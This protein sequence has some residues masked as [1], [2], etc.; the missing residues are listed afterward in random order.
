MLSFHKTLFFAFLLFV[1]WLPIPLG[2]NRPWAW[3]LN[4]IYV[5]FL[6]LGCL[7]LL[8]A[9]QC[10]LAIQRAKVILIPVALFTLWSW[11]QSWPSLGLS[12][13]Q[14]LVFISAVKSLHYLQICLVAA[15]LVDTPHKLKMLAT[16]MIASGICQAFYAGVILLLELQTSPFFSLPLNQ[17]ASGSFVYH[18]HLANFLMLNLCL[19]FG[20]LIAELN[21]QTTQ[22]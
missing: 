5:A 21:H 20:L 7:F 9:A 11:M 6:L 12:S 16:T 1:F 10:W 17:R 4:E 15:L 19:G 8:P 13:D 3:S 2:S 22:G 14:T 18:N